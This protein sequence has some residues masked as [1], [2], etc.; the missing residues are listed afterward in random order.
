MSRPSSSVPN[1]KAAPGG[2]SRPVR[3]CAVGD[4]W[5]RSGATSA[6][7][8]SRSTIAKPMTARRLR[9]KATAMRKAWRRRAWPGEDG[10]STSRYSRQLSLGGGGRE[11]L[12]LPPERR[13]PR[14][15]LIAPPLSSRPRI[16]HAIEHVGSKV[17][18]DEDD[19]DDHGAAEHR[20]HV[21]IEQRVGE[22]G[23][24]AGPGEDGLGE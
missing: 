19:A 22:V 17:E 13:G 15:P 9:A 2:C 11:R 16:E 4:W 24:D 10:V 3:S 20:V 7:S 8:T 5:A 21:G 14:A 1:Q 23:A 6:V 18:A 12:S